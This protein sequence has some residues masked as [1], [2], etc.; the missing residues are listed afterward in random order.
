MLERSCYQ[1]REKG[2]KEKS[3]YNDDLMMMMMM[4][5]VWVNGQQNVSMLHY[6]AGKYI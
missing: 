4:L 5:M 1:N 6:F 3:A 2:N